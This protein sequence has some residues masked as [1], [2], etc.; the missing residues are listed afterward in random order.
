VSVDPYGNEVQWPLIERFFYKAEMVLRM[1]D[2]DANN[3][4]DDDDDN[5]RASTLLAQRRFP[6]FVNAP[7]PLVPG[8]LCFALARFKPFGP[9]TVF[10]RRRQMASCQLRKTWLFF[11]LMLLMAEAPP[12]SIDARLASHAPLVVG[13]PFAIDI[14]VL[15]LNAFDV[16]RVKVE[17]LQT[18]VFARVSGSE[19]RARIG[20]IVVDTCVVE[21]WLSTTMIDFVDFFVLFSSIFVDFRLKKLGW[22]WKKSKPTTTGNATTVIHSLQKQYVV[23]FHICFC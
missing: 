17:L 20:P 23:H 4:D 16:S 15:T 11:V 13:Q 22:N 10:N 5:R 6:Q 1:Y 2:I 12:V 14:N 3:E 7:P 9:S 8:Q 21:G 19:G 18:S